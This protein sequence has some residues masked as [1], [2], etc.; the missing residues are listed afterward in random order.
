MTQT[1][2][3]PRAELAKSRLMVSM[4]QE[5]PSV[6]APTHADNRLLFCVLGTPYGILTV[7]D[8]DQIEISI[9]APGQQPHLAHVVNNDEACI[10]QAVH[11][12]FEQIASGRIF[13]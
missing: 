6:V 7:I 2:S 3:T 8:E 4:A 10:T 1:L 11:T 5:R 12:V 9:K 13:G